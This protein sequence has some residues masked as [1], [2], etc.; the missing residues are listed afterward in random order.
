MIGSKHCL[1]LAFSFVLSSGQIFA[2]EIYDRYI[3]EASAQDCENAWQSMKKEHKQGD[4]TRYSSVTESRFG[5]YS[6]RVVSESKTTVVSNSEEN[7]HLKY[8]NKVE[9]QEPQISE[10]TL[11]HGTF[12][13]DCQ[14]AQDTQ[15]NGRTEKGTETVTVPAGTFQTEWTLF[16]NSENGNELESKSFFAKLASGR[17]L[18][19]K[20]I[21]DMRMPY[22]TS[23][24]DMVLLESNKN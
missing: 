9:G 3:L 19:V 4:M 1:A 7:I 2:N 8:E 20:S 10:I 21:S 17:L 16:K 11:N 23:H 5:E 22:G 14:N 18:M 6:S 15:P 24:T 12:V 13:R